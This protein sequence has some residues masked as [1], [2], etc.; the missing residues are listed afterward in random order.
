MRR[1]EPITLLGAATVAWPIV[2]RAQEGER[3]RRIGALFGPTEADPEGQA[4]AAALRQLVQK[5][6][7]TE[8]A[9]SHRYRWAGGGRDRIVQLA[10]ELVSRKPEVIF[11][12]ATT[13]LAVLQQATR[14]VPIVFAQVTD[15]SVPA[16]SSLARPGEEHHG[17][18]QHEFTIGSVKSFELLK[19]LA[20][21]VTRVAILHDP[22]NP[23]TSPLHPRD[24]PCPLARWASPVGLSDE[25]RCEIAMP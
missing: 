21:R 24:R 13:A 3:V 16:S 7:W 22:G 4:R 17:V 25:R 10:A 9:I 23:A 11:A 5:S 6:G 12:S 19:Q 8:G 1:R 14:T 20:P 18:T 2:A 15:P